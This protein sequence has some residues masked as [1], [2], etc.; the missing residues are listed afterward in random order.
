MSDLLKFLENE[1]Q[2]AALL[3]LALIYVGRLV[4]LFRFKSRRTG[5][6]PPDAP[7]PGPAI[8]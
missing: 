7:V 2:I 8:P 5:P 1:V 3:F 4:W 6:S